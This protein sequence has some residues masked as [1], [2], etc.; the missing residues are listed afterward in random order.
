MTQQP[1]LQPQPLP[2]HWMVE[3][4]IAPNGEKVV[5]VTLTMLNGVHKSF[6]PAEAAKRIALDMSSA[7]SGLI[8]AHNGDLNGN[9]PA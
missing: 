7:A 2:E 8:V 4:A 3:A 1:L 5:I 9:P 6:L